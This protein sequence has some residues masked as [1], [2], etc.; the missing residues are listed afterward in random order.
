[1]GW[2][3]VLQLDLDEPEVADLVADLHRRFGERV[4]TTTKVGWLHQMEHDEA[5]AAVD[6]VARLPIEQP[7]RCDGRRGRPRL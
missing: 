7:G 2:V 3:C 4:K 6:R 1:M 5:K